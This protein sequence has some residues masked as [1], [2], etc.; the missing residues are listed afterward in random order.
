MRIY[1]GDE[2]CHDDGTIALYLE[3]RHGLWRDHLLMAHNNQERGIKWQSAS[4][5]ERGWALDDSSDAP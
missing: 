5:S 1:L 3:V 2:P 4:Y